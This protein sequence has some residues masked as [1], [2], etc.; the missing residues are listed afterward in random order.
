MIRYEATRNE[1]EALVDA[2]K[3]SWRGRAAD[4]TQDLITAGKFNESSSIWSEIKPAFMAI[5]HNKCVFCER[6]LESEQYGRIE[7]DLEH[8]RPKG[9][10]TGWPPASGDLS[11]NFEMGA[12]S[13]TG[14]FWLAYDLGNYATACK[15]CN[16]TLK[17]DAFPI[18]GGRGVA[19][20]SVEDL[21][22]DEKPYLCYPIG[23]SDEDPEEL[24]DFD[25]VVARPRRSRGLRWRRAKVIIAFFRL[26]RESLVIERAQQLTLIGYPLRDIEDGVDVAWNEELVEGAIQVNQPHAACKRAFL[27]LWDDDRNRAKDILRAAQRVA[28]LRPPL[29]APGA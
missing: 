19:N 7:H 16:S 17:S 26:N 28:Y 2:E 24:I 13:D 11:F 1:I 4:R 6:V 10:V 12:A 8:F 25:G 15:T 3:A 14:Y 20:A 5:Q 9:R 23:D 29:T 21:L 27:R 22:A 18:A